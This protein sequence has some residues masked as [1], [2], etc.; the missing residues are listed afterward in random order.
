VNLAPCKKC[1]TPQKKQI[2]KCIACG[3]ILPNASKTDLAIYGFLIYLTIGMLF[4]VWPEN[5]PSK[6]LKNIS[7]ESKIAEY[8]GIPWTEEQ[9]PESFKKWD[10]DT[11]EKINSMLRPA[12]LKAAEDPACDKVEIV[13]MSLSRSAPPESITYYI[14]CLNGNRLYVSS[15]TLNK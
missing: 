15:E 3:K 1:G 12:A 9:Y 7:P 10:S 4:T 11:I 13:E 6:K 5:T 2:F 8:A 14:D